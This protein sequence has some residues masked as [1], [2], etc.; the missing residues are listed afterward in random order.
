MKSHLLEEDK[1]KIAIESIIRYFA[2]E[3]DETI[4]IIAANSFLD[5]VLKN[6]GKDIYNKGVEDSRAKLLEKLGELDFNLE[7]LKK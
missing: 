4:G 5:F 7:E 3:R 1:K 6:F 2:K